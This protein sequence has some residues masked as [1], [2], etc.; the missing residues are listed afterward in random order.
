[1]RHEQ[2]TTPPPP[3]KSAPPH[4]S[5]PPRRRRGD[6][7]ARAGRGLSGRRRGRGAR[8]GCGPDP[9][10]VL[11]LEPGQPRD[12]RV[13]ARRA[14][15]RRPRGGRAA[16]LH[17]V[18]ERL[19]RPL[20]LAEVR[21]PVGLRPG[22]AADQRV[23]QLAVLLQLVRP[24]QGHP[25]QGRG[26]LGRLDGV[27]R[28]HAVRLGQRPGLRHGSFRG[29]R[30]DR[31]PAGRL[32]GRLRGR[33]GRLGPA[34]AVRDLADRRVHLPV[35][36]RQPDARPA[37]RQSTGLRPGLLGAVAAGG[38]LAG[39]LRLHRLPGQRHRAARPVDERV[40]H[41]AD[42]V[43]HPDA[44]GR[45]HAQRLRRPVGQAG[46]AALPDLRHG[47]RP[48]RRPG[49]RHRAVRHDRLV[50]PGHH[51]LQ[52]LHRPLLGPRRLDPARR[53]WRY[54]PGAHRRDRRR[55]H[56]QHRL[57]ELGRGHRRGLLPGLPRRHPGRF[58]DRDLL[59]RHRADGG[60]G[61]Q[62]HGRGGGLLRRGRRGL[63]RGGRDHHRRWRIRLGPVLHRQQ[64]QPG[65]GGP[66]PPERRLH[67]RGRLRPEHGPVESVHHPHPEGD[68]RGLLRHRGRHLLTARR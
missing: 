16:R 21:R 57:A 20:R 33:R 8:R 68:R 19:L 15:G 13:R 30:H 12:V 1:M 39:R 28:G 9:G 42:R 49:V 61:V 65:R 26:G 45:H 7:G 54:A 27:A 62:L 41:R 25:R 34:R 67:V 14:A 4:P 23:E 24:G 32:S 52:L 50:L 18:G 58:A 3:R 40:G 63:V 22:A 44:A 56:R 35:R 43:V 38:D 59:H 11:R 29:R 47:P 6:R 46:G 66:R 55:H 10:D 37:G 17:A 51:L 53:R 5:P 48:G 2:H 31:R 60:H 64:L 36:Q